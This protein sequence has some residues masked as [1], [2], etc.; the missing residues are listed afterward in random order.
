MTIKYISIICKS[1]DF[2][3]LEAFGKSLIYNVNN[4]SPNIE[5]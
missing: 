4:I 1:T 2:N 5:P 3:N